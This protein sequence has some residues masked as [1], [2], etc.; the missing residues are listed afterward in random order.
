M[1]QESSRR[2]TQQGRAQQENR[3]WPKQS[4]P[5]LHKCGQ[6]PV[7]PLWDYFFLN[8]TNSAANKNR[9]RAMRW[10]KTK[11]TGNGI[12]SEHRAWT[13]QGSSFVSWIGGLGSQRGPG[14][15]NRCHRSSQDRVCPLSCVPPP[16]CSFKE[17]KNPNPPAA[18]RFFVPSRQEE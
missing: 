9:E 17:A 4:H 8:A 1:E 7:F 11:I 14:A 15:W 13:G 16:L 3:V 18:S 2:V 12:K 6:T 10:G 5:S